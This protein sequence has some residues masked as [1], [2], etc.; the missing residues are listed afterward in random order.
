MKNDGLMLITGGAGFVGA[1]LAI[2]FKH[3]QPDISI[4]ALDNLKRRG[5]EL[6]LKRLAQNN[7]QFIHGDIR[8]KE[9]L[10][11][12][13]NKISIIV[14]C[15]AE[16][17]VLAGYDEYP[18]Y[19]LDTNL[20]GAI[21]CL[22]LARL[23]GADFIFL[24][25]SRIYPF[26]TINSLSYYEDETRFSL[27]NEQTIAGA[28]TSG[29]SESFPLEGPRSLYG[30]TKLSV[31]YIALEYAAMYDV[32]VIIDRCGVIAGPWQMGKIDQGVF[33]LWVASHYF[34][35]RLSY[36][37]FG[38]KGKQVRD[39][40]HIDDLFN[41]LLLQIDKIAQY[42]GNIYNV[43]GGLK[44]TLSLLETTRLCEELTSQKT[45]I[46]GEL[47]ERPA[48]IKSYIS[49]CRKI[50]EK[51][52]WQPQK[53]VQEILKDIYEWIHTYENELRPILG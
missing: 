33:T 19:V 1:N 28:S 30:A 26:A 35:K 8:N 24:S 36:I 31:E 45:L 27:T 15:S 53:T 48:D 47:T 13:K 38:G 20:N 3:A 25:T 32:N 41:L 43:G 2:A 10:Q 14:E 42:N 17:S 46:E 6:N 21:N 5:S 50:Q 29:I 11:F 34:R 51:Y 4:V 37:G 23:H 9:D 18:G 49:D 16:P 12:S 22:E 7:I 52:G 39:V 44:N 40:L